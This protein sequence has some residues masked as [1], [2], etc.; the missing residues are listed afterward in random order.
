MK[1]LRNWAVI[2]IGSILAAHTSDGISF[3][4]YWTLLVGVL[5]ISLLNTLIR[6]LLILFTLPFIIFT[7]GLGLVLINALLVKCTGALVDGF[8]VASWWSAIWAALVI[9]MTSVFAN[10]FFAENRAKVKAHLRTRG[11]RQAGQAH[12]TRREVITEDDV[13]DI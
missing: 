8:E 4:S 13:I 3:D 11:I 5:I 12:R 9:G 6:P 7:L 10:I 2:A 1:W